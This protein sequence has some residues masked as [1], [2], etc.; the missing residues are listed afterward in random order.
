MQAVTPGSLK[1]SLGLEAWVAETRRSMSRSGPEPP[2]RSGRA[3]RSPAL[4]L[5]TIGKTALR[6]A[7]GKRITLTGTCPSRRRPDS[8]S[9]PGPAARSIQAFARMTNTTRDGRP[10]SS[11]SRHTHESSLSASA[12]ATPAPPQMLCPLLAQSARKPSMPLSV[13]GCLNSARITDGGA[14]ITSAPI[15]ALSR[16]WIGWR[17]LATRISVRKS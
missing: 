10:G 13:S 15:L 12:R 5:R 6:Q 9:Q 8:I 4:R 7:Q 1:D 14:V 11:G 17:T 2:P 3:C 16:T